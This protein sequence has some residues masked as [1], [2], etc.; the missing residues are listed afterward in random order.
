M[1]LWEVTPCRLIYNCHW[2]GGELRPSATL[3]T[4][5]SVFSEASATVDVAI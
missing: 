5:A 3:N 2:L 1:V 4:E